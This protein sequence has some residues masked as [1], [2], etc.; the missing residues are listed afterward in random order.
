M[1]DRACRLLSLAVLL[2]GCHRDPP[3]D[4]APAE[5]ARLD[6]SPLRTRAAAVTIRFSSGGLE[7]G[8]TALGADRLQVSAVF[9]DIDKRDLP[10]LA[11]LVGQPTA[12][13]VTTPDSCVRQA[14]AWQRP[15][16]R[17]V[18]EPRAWLQ[19]LDV[20]NVSLQAATARLPLRV[21]MV[22]SLVHA[23][24]GV[25]Y[26]GDQ[27]QSRPWLAAGALRLL[28]TGGDG[29]APFEA[30]I[31][32]PRPVRLT[33]VGSQP[34]RSGRVQAPD[35]PGEFLLRWGSVDGTAEL[36]VQIGSE[37]PGGLGWVRCRLRDDGEFT[38]PSSLIHLLPPRMP[39]RPWLV[40]LVRSRR[41]A[42]PGFEGT[43][44]RLEVMDSAY[45]Q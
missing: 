16:A 2:L 18:A 32:P 45:V 14:E 22:P 11:D 42:I 5:P 21:Q 1:L 34:V 9:A 13:E 29:V 7:P 41:A 43:P 39:E 37:D 17:P 6:D 35:E 28:A 25:R 19:L 30:R 3:P 12:P 20:G 4:E 26:D 31:E 23:I 40:V 38:V 24:R 27:D 8:S 15:G 10:V 33:Y 44:L 36:E